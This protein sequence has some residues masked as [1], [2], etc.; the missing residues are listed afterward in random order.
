LLHSSILL[1]KKLSAGRFD[2]REST[3]YLADHSFACGHGKTCEIQRRLL[4]LAHLGRGYKFKANSYCREPGSFSPPKSTVATGTSVAASATAKDLDIPAL[5]R[6][7]KPA[8]VQI[9]TFDQENK[10]QKKHG[11]DSSFQPMAI[12]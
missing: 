8:V 6:Q 11:P 4:E 3:H 2:R 7:A 1:P 9:V 10:P 5:V 12:C